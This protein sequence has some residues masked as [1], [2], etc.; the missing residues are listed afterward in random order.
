MFRPWMF[1]S[2]WRRE[3]Q[4]RVLMWML[5]SPWARAQVSLRV[6]M[7]RPWMHRP[8]AAEQGDRANEEA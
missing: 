2:T 6:L 3:L 5:L 7:C 4:L 8:A 1:R